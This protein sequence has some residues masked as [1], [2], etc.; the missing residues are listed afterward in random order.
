MAEFIGVTVLVT[1]RDPL[2]ALIR[3]QVTNVVRQRLTLSP[4]K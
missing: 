2:N 4:G 3:G 1:L